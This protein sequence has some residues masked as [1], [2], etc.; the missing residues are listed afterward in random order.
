MRMAH[1]N[2][3]RSVVNMSGYFNVK[4]RRWIDLLDH[5]CALQEIF[6]REFPLGAA[7]FRKFF[8]TVST[9]KDHFVKI[10]DV[11]LPRG[12][13]SNNFIYCPQCIVESY[14]PIFHD[15]AKIGFCLHHGC[16]LIE[17]CPDCKTTEHWYS[18][19]LF[20]CKCGFDRR[21]ATRINRTLMP[22]ATDPFQSS[23]IIKDISF[24]YAIAQLCASLLEVRRPA[25]DFE[26]YPLP[27]QVINHIDEVIVA[28]LARYP[29]FI[30][31][32]HR[33][34]WIIQGSTSISWLADRALA[35]H[36]SEC[37]SCPTENCCRLAK[38]SLEVAKFAVFGGVKVAANAVWSHGLADCGRQPTQ[39]KDVRPSCQIIREAH[40]KYLPNFKPISNDLDG[41]TR[42][43]VALLLKCSLVVV[44]ELRCK[45]WL[46]P[47][48]RTILSQFRLNNVYSRTSAERFDRLFSLVKDFD[49]GLAIPIYSSAQ[50]IKLSS[51]EI[52]HRRNKP[53][54]ESH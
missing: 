53:Y 27:L 20:Q 26:S 7:A 44:D 30:Y 1:Y 9:G 51:G 52:F 6:I 45:G 41:L 50:N 32:L 28:Q 8:Y 38:V 13:C 33:A 48:S 31:S 47:I 4:P 17:A 21:T 3:F 43:E 18:A 2:G 49:Q 37:R 14:S 22:P 19:K 46:E 15:I 25:R 24:A 54:D 39:D 29:G 16:E 5:R 12:S 42:D 35:R 34:P 23:H 10:D 40:T 11:S 36:F